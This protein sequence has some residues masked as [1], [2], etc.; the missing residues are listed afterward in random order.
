VTDDGQIVDPQEGKKTQDDFANALR[1]NT[2]PVITPR[3]YDVHL[4]EQRVLCMTVRGAAK[5]Q[6]FS[7]FGRY[8]IRV[9]KAN[10][11]MSPDQIKARLLEGQRPELN[12]AVTIPV[13]GQIEAPGATDQAARESQLHPPYPVAEVDWSEERDRPNFEVSRRALK[14]LEAEFEPMM[15][16]QHVSGD[17]IARLEWRFRGPRFP[18]EW[19][20]ASGSALARTHFVGRFDLS[21]P[22]SEDDKVGLDEMGFEIR[23][24]WRGL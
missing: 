15:T 8:K 5:G 2:D 13:I 1:A 24:H 17:R 4:N 21:Q 6:V 14:G 16:V 19:R 12:R 22:P 9:G 18:A 10:L 3:I 7:A 23:F 20:Q 11:D